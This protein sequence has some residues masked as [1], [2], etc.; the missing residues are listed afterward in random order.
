M[1]KFARDP[2][3][4]KLLTLHRLHISEGYSDRKFRL[5]HHSASHITPQKYRM[6]NV[7][8]LTFII[9]CLKDKIIREI[10]FSHV[11]K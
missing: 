8:A 1:I 3:A 2:S 10:Y 11:I 7:L 6:N 5:S 4:E 9:N